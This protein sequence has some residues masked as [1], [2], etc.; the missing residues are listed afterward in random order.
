[1]IT[2][3]HVSV[4]KLGRSDRLAVMLNDHAPGWQM[5]SE[6]DLFEGTG[7]GDGKGLAVGKDGDVGGRGHWVSRAG[8]VADPLL[9]ADG[10]AARSLP[11]RA[12]ADLALRGACWSTALAWAR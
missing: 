8:E 7:K 9:Q 11:L 2:W 1:M 12:K 6:K 10:V 3:G 4:G 5:L